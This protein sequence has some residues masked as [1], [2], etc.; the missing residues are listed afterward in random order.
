MFPYIYL[1]VLKRVQCVKWIT[2]HY[3][4]FVIQ[5]HHTVTQSQ[6]ATAGCLTQKG[7]T[8]VWDNF[9]V[10]VNLDDNFTLIPLDPKSESILMPDER[11]AKFSSL[12]EV[13]RL[14]ETWFW[15]VSFGFG[16]SFDWLVLANRRNNFADILKS[17]LVHSGRLV[18]TGSGC[19]LGWLVL[20]LMLQLCGWL[21]SDQ[22]VVVVDYYSAVV[23]KLLW[24]RRR[25]RRRRRT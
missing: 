20:V 17:K 1:S 3:I 19:G 5:C 15:L 14:G 16:F 4:T 22:E 21:K 18:L 6:A 24:S 13:L 9:T 10:K 7:N 25:S 12:T 8:P 2:Y 11:K 23:T